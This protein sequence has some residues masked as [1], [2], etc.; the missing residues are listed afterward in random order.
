MDC[1]TGPP[2]RVCFTG[3]CTRAVFRHGY[4]ARGRDRPRMP[5]PAVQVPSTFALRSRRSRFR[6]R[7]FS[8]RVRESGFP[9]PPF[10]VSHRPGFRRGETRVPRFREGL[11]VSSERR[12][13]LRR[14]FSP[15]RS[16]RRGRRRAGS[17]IRRRFR[18]GISVSS[19]ARFRW[20]LRISRSPPTLPCPEPSPTE[21][22]SMQTRPFVFARR[23]PERT[24]PARGRFRSPS[25]EWGIATSAA[26]ARPRAEG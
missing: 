25:R 22:A 16:F 13:F 26:T 15:E 5:K 2:D 20:D 21:T 9:D 19:P 6:R 18:R 17:P 24:E 23:L 12:A 4:E 3:L 8:C 11:R 1:I 14:D 7:I 10:A